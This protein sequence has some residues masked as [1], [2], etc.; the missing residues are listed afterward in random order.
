MTQATPTRKSDGR[1]MTLIAALLGWMFDGLE[2]GLF[3]LVA[4]P[5][6]KE[7]L[8]TTDPTEVARWIGVITAGFLVGAA[9]GGVLFGWLGDRIGRVRAMTLSVLTYA[10]FSGACGLVS[11]AWQVAVLR[12]IASLGMGGE[13]S[14]GVALVME[15]WPNRSRAWLA[16]LIG[17]AANIGYMVIAVVGLV[18]AEV[19]KDLESL[20]IKIGLSETTTA[21]LAGND[22][23]R[24]LMLF[25]ALPA[26]LT[27]LIRLFVPESGRWEEEN[28]KGSTSHWQTKDLSGVV[29][30]A[31]AACGLI[32]LW[33]VPNIHVIVRVVGS[34]VLFVVIL[35]GYLFPIV[36]Y[37]QRATPDQPEEL[38]HTVKLLLIAAALSGVALLGTW[39]STQ[40]APTLANILTEGKDPTAKSYT[41][42]C[43]AGGAAIGCV[44]AA[45]SGGW[46]G[47]RITY[48]VLCALSLGAVANLFLLNKSYNNMYLFSSF[49]AGAIT[50][51]FYGWLPLY[52]PELFRTKVRATAQGFGFNFGRILAA[53]G[54]LQL[55]NVMELFEVGW[56]EA[57]QIDPALH[58]VPKELAEAFGITGLRA[59]QIGNGCCRKEE[60]PHATEA[61]ELMWNT[62]F[63]RGGR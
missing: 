42:L 2:M 44:L 36:R 37:I 14:L 39:G 20:L 51:A 63:T 31:V 28:R 35:G 48:A 7:L 5:A 6:L 50:A 61:V 33:A 60:R 17:A 25:G 38:K 27:F 19:T 52:L 43:T 47:R 34:L 59:L 26:L 62:G 57:W 3:P 29:I 15:V 54:V 55:R 18:L 56:P 1:W 16:G 11:E 46:F 45:L 23:W 4:G 22:G 8:G 13:W 58:H 12:F 24:I 53:I 30:G 41:Q 9:T 49:M 32:A 10:L 21:W 40:W